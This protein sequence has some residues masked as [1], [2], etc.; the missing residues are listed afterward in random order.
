[1]FDLGYDIN[2]LLKKSL[3]MMGS[4]KMGIFQFNCV[5]PTNTRLDFPH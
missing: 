5:S 2:I 3:E 1:M 4:P